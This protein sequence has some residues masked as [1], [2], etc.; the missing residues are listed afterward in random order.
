[1]RSIQKW[2]GAPMK[3]RDEGRQRYSD[4]DQQRPAEKMGPSGAGPS[5]CCNPHLS[6]NLFAPSSQDAVKIHRIQIV[7]V[8]QCNVVV[9]AVAP[10][11]DRRGGGG[12]HWSSDGV[13][14]G[15]LDE[16]RLR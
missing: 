12:R 8:R 1:M 4:K 14:F 10:Y 7:R 6:S 15:S 16:T 13:W 9:A 2:K 3:R 11:R 5:G